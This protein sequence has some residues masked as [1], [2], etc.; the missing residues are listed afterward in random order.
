MRLRDCH[1]EGV[2]ATGRRVDDAHLR[3][4]ARQWTRAAWQAELYV[5]NTWLGFPILQWPSDMLVLQQIVFE[6]RPRVIVESGTHR[7]GSAVYYASLLWLLGGGKVVSVDLKIP[8]Q[9]RRAIAAS[10][11]A[12]MIAL[13]QGDSKSPEVVRRV[14]E[15]IGDEG[16][17]LVALDSDHSRAHVLAELRA[18]GGFVPVG[19][20]LIAMDT[21]C[22][23][24]WDL[25]RG[26][27]QWKDDNPLRAVEDFLRE[28]PEF[29]VDQARERLL[30]TFSPG[31]FLRRARR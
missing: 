7:G 27:P 9:V 16:N 29:E 31:G 5:G 8:N 3:D 24:L 17:V 23:D 20:Y 12:D 30:V 26:S 18:Y 6:Q 15:A 13:V 22:H 19:G 28:H 21:I 4:L 14:G 25:P 1:A 11:F 2:P 10:P